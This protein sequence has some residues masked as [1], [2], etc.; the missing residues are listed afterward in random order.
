MRPELDVINSCCVL[1]VHVQD[2]KHGNQYKTNSSVV[3]AEELNVW[4]LNYRAIIS[5][6]PMRYF[7]RG[8]RAFDQV[9]NHRRR[10]YEINGNPPCQSMELANGLSL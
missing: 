1:Y 3:Q 4:V 7:N 6:L 9:D 8:M 2:G 5:D 10:R